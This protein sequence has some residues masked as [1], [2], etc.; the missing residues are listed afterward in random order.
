MKKILDNK[1]INT[2]ISTIEGII[3]FFLFCI[4]VITLFQRINGS[5]FGYRIYTVASASM[6]PNY[7]VGDVLLVEK[8]KLTDIDVGDAVT[9]LGEAPTVKDMIITHRVEKIEKENGIYYFH[10]KGIANNIEDPIVEGK[11]IIGKVTHKFYFLSFIGRITTN[12]YKIFFFI[13]VPIAVLIA[14][15]IIKTIK[16]KDEEDE[17]E[18]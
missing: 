12:V 1:I 3:C 8:V 13:T 17:E 15:E 10:T 16:E 2:I 18:T 6:I 11:Q 5:F 14:I 4:V 7:N 9:Y